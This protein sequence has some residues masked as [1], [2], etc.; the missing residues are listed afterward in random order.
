MTAGNGDFFLMDVILNRELQRSTVDARLRDPDDVVM[1]SAKWDKANLEPECDFK[2]RSLVAY[3]PGAG[4]FYCCRERRPAAVGLP[5]TPVQHSASWLRIT[6]D[7]GPS[8][9]A[10]RCSFGA[11]G[12]VR[13]FYEESVD[14]VSAWRVSRG[15][16][17]TGRCPPRLVVRAQQC[18]DCD[19]P[20]MP[21]DTVLGKEGKREDISHL[22]RA[23]RV[24]RYN[25]N[26]A[27][28]TAAKVGC[29]HYARGSHHYVIPRDCLVIN[30]DDAGPHVDVVVDV[31]PR[32]S[33]KAHKSVVRVRN[34][35][36]PKMDSNFVGRSGE[37][38]LTHELKTITLHNTILR[39][40]LRIGGGRSS[41]GDI[42]AM[43]PIGTRVLQDGIRT[44]S[45]LATR[46]VSRQLVEAYVKALSRVGQI[47][48]PDVLAV[49]QDAEGD[50]GLKPCAA[51]AG[52]EVGNRVGMS[53]DTSV[54]L[55]NASHFDSNDA[56]QCY[57]LFLEEVP[58]MADNWYFVLPNVHGDRPDGSGSFDGLAIKI[59]HGTAIS[60]D[61]RVIRHCTSVSRP[62]GPGTCF[63]SG[64]GGKKTTNHLFGTFT[65]AK[66]KIIH[67]GRRR[68]TEIML[69][70]DGFEFHVEDE[71]EELP[72]YD[73]TV[74]DAD[75][76]D[77]LVPKDPGDWDWHRDEKKRECD[78]K[79]KLDYIIPK[80]QRL[81]VHTGGLLDY[82][83]PKKQRQV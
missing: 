2:Y 23:E 64:Y 61:G 33:F 57:S 56:S 81:G 75:P 38:M 46:L 20:R 79:R 5:N 34:I 36:S 66:E 15:A 72:P 19:G 78:E 83:I 37:P 18:S 10:Q 11:D 41:T 45:Y 17:G 62:D 71:G 29:R 1:V 31:A 24:A 55:G 27:S 49:I 40:R 42:G 76:D 70:G 53:I 4:V 7:L 60:W 63:A 51:M 3:L 74:D 12:F 68:A 21:P 52:D 59:R 47:L 6:E 26:L 14:W 13:R 69:H 65:A 67:A 30:G 43:H 35:L 44:T 39:K 28:S 73:P 22:P 16:Y 77:D 82:V 32:G 50:T 48:F 80:K 54:D 8:P 25:A 9:T 58:G